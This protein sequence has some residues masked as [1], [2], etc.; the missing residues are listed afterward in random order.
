[1][2]KVRRLLRGD[3]P[4][5]LYRLDEHYDAQEI[6]AEVAAAGWR[7]FHLDGRRV[8]DKASFL[9]EIARAM[10]FPDY[11]GHN[12]DALDELLRDLSWA[13]AKGYLLLY[14]HVIQFARHRPK[15][16]QM[17]RQILEDAMAHWRGEGVPFVVILRGA[18]R[19]APDVP[20]L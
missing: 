17:A 5:G 15:E 6:L 12:W 16:W 10:D 7:G 1:M 2:S 13:P 18:E 20:W 9:A 14:D 8:T 3:R 4:P 11:F 19:A